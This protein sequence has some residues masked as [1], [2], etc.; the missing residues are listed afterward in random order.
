[1]ASV[2]FVLGTTS[3]GTGRHVRSLA[4]GLAARG[5]AVAVAGPAATQRL[6]GFTGAGARFV[7]VEISDRP[8]PARDL[9]AVARLRRLLRHGKDGTGQGGTGQGGTRPRLGVVH[10]H[11]LRAGA[12]TALALGGLRPRP[13]RRGSAPVFVVTLH[14]APPAGGRAAAVY[15]ILE[16]IV[17]RRADLVL[18]VSA[19]L[20]TRI[21]RRGATRTTPSTAWTRSS[22]TCCPTRTASRTTCTT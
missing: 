16:R 14:N 12:L 18:C 2:T 8:R 17:A 1:V 22:S 3:G 7:P 19:D 4:A 20:A 15:G 10:A 6:P 21:R 13:P 11:G 9:A 5:V